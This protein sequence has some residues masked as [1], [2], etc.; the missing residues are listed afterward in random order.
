MAQIIVKRRDHVEEGGR[1]SAVGLIGRRLGAYLEGL[2]VLM[3]RA[4]IEKE[5][6]SEKIGRNDGVLQAWLAPFQC[7]GSPPGEREG[8]N[9]HNFV[10]KK[11]K[12]E[13]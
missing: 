5:S 12:K 3:C 2:Q 10:I 4:A 1:R 7:V 13:K 11:K 8:V 6:P 9:K